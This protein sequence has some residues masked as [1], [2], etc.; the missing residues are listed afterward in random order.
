MAWKNILDLL[1]DRQYKQYE[2]FLD[3]V[4][5]FGKYNKHM[6]NNGAHYISSKQNP[7]RRKGIKCQ[8]KHLL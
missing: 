4:K 2:K 3:I 6:N 5:H 1:S 7:F 8:K